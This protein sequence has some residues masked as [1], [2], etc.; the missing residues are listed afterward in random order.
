MKH[1]FEFRTSKTQYMK[2]NFFNI[3]DLCL[4]LIKSYILRE[5]KKRTTK[6]QKTKKTAKI[7]KYINEKKM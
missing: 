6:K 3:N 7:N 2:N 1:T 5:K 4:Y